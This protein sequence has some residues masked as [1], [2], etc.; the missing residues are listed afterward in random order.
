G[1][2]TVI[3]EFGQI[4]LTLPTDSKLDVDLKTDFGGISSDLPITMVIN[5]SSNSNEEQMVGSINGGGAQ[6]TVQTN[7]GSVN[8]HTSK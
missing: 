1:P 2:H 3:S 6:L 4:E 7:S 5:G 8:I